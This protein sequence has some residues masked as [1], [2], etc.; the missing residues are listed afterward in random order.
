MMAASTRSHLEVVRLLCDAGADKDKADN[1][2][3]TALIWASTR[4]HLEVARLLCEAGADKDK[5]KQDGDTA[6][7]IASGVAAALRSRS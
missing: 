5:A 4:G 3:C 7:M 1:S 2:G 6:L